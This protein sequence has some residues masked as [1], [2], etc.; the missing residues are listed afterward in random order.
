MIISFPP[1]AMTG[2]DV[3]RSSW[4]VLVLVLTRAHRRDCTRG[5]LA[6]E[7]ERLRSQLRSG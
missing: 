4:L 3:E 5:L 2:E 7:L 6:T 1:A